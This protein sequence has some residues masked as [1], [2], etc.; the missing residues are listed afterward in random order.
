MLASW[1]HTPSTPQTPSRLS[2]SPG[3]GGRV[4]V[5]VPSVSQAPEPSAGQVLVSVRLLPSCRPCGSDR[6]A[7]QVKRNRCSCR[8]PACVTLTGSQGVQ[9]VLRRTSGQPSGLQVLNSFK[10]ETTTGVLPGMPA[11]LPTH[12]G[13]QNSIPPRLHPPSATLSPLRSLGRSRRFHKPDAEIAH[14]PHNCCC[15]CSRS[16]TKPKRWAPGKACFHYRT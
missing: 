2:H 16:P 14:R 9:G 13:S 3:T 11:G 8:A 6:G 7:R 10:G 1:M 12:M 5:G 4:E 15:I